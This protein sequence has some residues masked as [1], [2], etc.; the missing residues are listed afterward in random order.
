MP[1]TPNEM[2]AT[3]CKTTDRG[4]GRGRAT[5]NE[6]AELYLAMRKLDAVAM[7]VV[8]APNKPCYD[9]V[10]AIIA[11]ANRYV[12]VETDPAYLLDCN[13]I[14]VRVQRCAL[15]QRIK[16]V[17]ALGDGTNSGATLVDERS[18]P[19]ARQLYR[20]LREAVH[21]LRDTSVVGTICEYGCATSNI[22]VLVRLLNEIDH[23]KYGEATRLVLEDGENDSGEL[24]TEGSG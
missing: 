7:R 2:D 17:R 13:Y 19:N 20:K 8:P 22:Q 23:S 24:P 10:L 3:R 16:R 18:T 9:E 4:R 21:A 15:A 6:R 12:R 14:F 11:M 1:Q 5:D